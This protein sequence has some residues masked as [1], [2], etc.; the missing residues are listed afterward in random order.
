MLPLT[1]VFREDR[2]DNTRVYVDVAIELSLKDFTLAHILHFIGF[3]I[4]SIT[5]QAVSVELGVFEAVT[6]E[7]LAQFCVDHNLPNRVVHIGASS[8]LTTSP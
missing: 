1:F 6:M 2:R 7:R 3:D 4:S 8:L 5:S